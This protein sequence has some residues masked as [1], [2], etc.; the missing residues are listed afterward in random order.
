MVTTFR[1]TPHRE[2]DYFKAGA[3]YSRE[4]PNINGQ[5]VVLHHNFYPETTVIN[6]Y[7]R[8]IVMPQHILDAYDYTHHHQMGDMSELDRMNHVDNTFLS[9]H[10]DE[11]RTVLWSTMVPALVKYE[12]VFCSV[13]C[14]R[15]PG[16][17]FTKNQRRMKRTRRVCRRCEENRQEKIAQ[18]NRILGSLSYFLSPHQC[19]RCLD[20]RCKHEFTSGR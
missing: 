1:N 2:T 10:D 16:F 19:A 12:S 9:C 20:Y 18:I 5:F 8:H 17:Y 3:D 11:E 6:V 15:L 14:C 13:C 4:P 7:D